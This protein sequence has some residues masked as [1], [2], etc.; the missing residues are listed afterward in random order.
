MFTLPSDAV[1]R[2]RLQC[3]RERHSLDAATGERFKHAP[4]RA[5]GIKG[6]LL[7]NM[8]FFCEWSLAGDRKK[9]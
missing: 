7:V 2:W 8:T 1:K 9:P 6:F 4:G 3:R 5:V